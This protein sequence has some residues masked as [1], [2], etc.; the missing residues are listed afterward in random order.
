VPPRIWI[1]VVLVVGLT[2]LPQSLREA[3][4]ARVGL[5]SVVAIVCGLGAVALQAIATDP[6]RRNGGI[7]LLTMLCWAV[8]LIWEYVSRAPGS[9]SWPAAV[10]ASL[11]LVGIPVTTT[12]IVTSVKPEPMWAF[13]QVASL[14]IAS[15][16]LSTLAALLAAVPLIGEGP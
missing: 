13:A 4:L 8:A 14:A 10:V 1:G 9:F 6:T 5:H 3:A 15:A 12:A 11:V 7:F 2:W 16:P